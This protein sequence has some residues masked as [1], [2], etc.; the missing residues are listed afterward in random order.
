VAI[1]FTFGVD[2]VGDLTATII[3][4]TAEWQALLRKLRPWWISQ[5]GGQ[6]FNF[7]VPLGALTITAQPPTT[8]N[9]GTNDIY[10]SGTN[11]DGVVFPGFTVP[12][13]F[14]GYSTWFLSPAGVDP[15]LGSH[16]AAGYVYLTLQAALNDVFF[17]S[18]LGAR[19][20]VV[21]NAVYSQAAAAAFPGVSGVAGQP[22]V[23]QG[24]PA[25]SALPYFDGGWNGS[26]YAPVGGLISFPNTTNYVTVR[27]LGCRNATHSC[28]PC[29]GTV[30]N[31]TIE[32]CAAHDVYYNVAGTASSSF[33]SSAFNQSLTNVIV[34]YCNI[35]TFNNAAAPFGPFNANCA[36]FETYG[37]NNVQFLNNYVAYANRGIRLKNADTGSG[38]TSGHS[39]NWTVQN[40]IFSNCYAAIEQATQGNNANG[41]SNWAINNN[42]FYGAFTAYGNGGHM[43]GAAGGLNSIYNQGTNVTVTNN[44]FGEDLAGGLSWTGVSSGFVFRDNVVMCNANAGTYL[45]LTP[46]TANNFGVVFSQLDYNAYLSS[47]SAPWQTDGVHTFATFAQWQNAFTATATPCLAIT[48]NPDPHGTS[49]AALGGGFNTEVANYPGFAS[50][51]YALAGGSPL[52]TASST[53]G[54]MGCNVAAIGPGW[55]G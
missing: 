6:T 39:D 55:F 5:I 8:L 37:S 25:V 2:A 26:S 52:Q 4:P 9:S 13:P 20:L 7:A 43:T 21:R 27:K 19:R 36:P 22:Y 51:N 18:G 40:N 16:Q 48:G 12:D 34:R 35:Y 14:S 1:N 41:L 30:S 17:A 33:V 53:G 46:T 11:P 50:R 47:A 45:L 31:L 38:A 24:D 49:I 44:T 3:I 15:A 29:D 10:P 32:Y 54:A 28:I 23:V 42:L